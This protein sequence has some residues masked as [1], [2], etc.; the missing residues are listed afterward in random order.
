MFFNGFLSPYGFAGFN[1]PFQMI[2]MAI[3]GIV[4]GIYRGQMPERF[5]S[6]SFC[7]ETSVLGALSALVFDLV[8]NVGVALWYVIS[9]IDFALAMLTAIAY[10]TFFS[11]VHI[12]SSAAVFGVLAL[13]SMKILDS[14]MEVRKNV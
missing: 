14:L 13:P 5:D 3:P 8:T 1:M 9:G 7:V 10:G 2:G 6:T 4:G 11:I 12:V